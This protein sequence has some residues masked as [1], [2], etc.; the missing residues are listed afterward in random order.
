MAKAASK[1]LGVVQWIR[2]LEINDR[3]DDSEPLGL[4]QVAAPKI[5]NTSPQSSLAGWYFE[6]ILCSTESPAVVIN[7]KCKG[8]NTTVAV[9]TF[10][11]QPTL[12]EVA[13]SVLEFYGESF[14]EEE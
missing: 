11:T 12:R 7:I 13:Q 3:L 10:D 6:A 2:Y 9:F 8:T 1:K 5:L 4:T 14:L